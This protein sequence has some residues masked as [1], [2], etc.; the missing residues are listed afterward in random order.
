MATEICNSRRLARGKIRVTNQISF[1]EKKGEVFAEIT[2]TVQYGQSTPI[3]DKFYIN[4]VKDAEF[5]AN[6]LL[7][8]I[9]SKTNNK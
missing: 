3:V 8:M 1:P 2:R 6:S 5:I 9:N 4:D 7:R